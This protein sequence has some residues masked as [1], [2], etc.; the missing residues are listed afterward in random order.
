MSVVIK[1][2]RVSETVKQRFRSKPRRKKSVFDDGE[3]FNYIE[4]PDYALK[5][6]Q[7]RFQDKCL[8]DLYKRYEQRAQ[9]GKY[10]KRVI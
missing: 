5:S 4:M 1:M 2:R 3:A 7:A 8:E 9:I 10:P 6:L